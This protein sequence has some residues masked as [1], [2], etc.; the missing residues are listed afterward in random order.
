MTDEELVLRTRAGDRA[1]FDVLAERYW[2]RCV[3]IAWIYVQHHQDAEDQAQIALW[4]AYIH[5]DSCDPARFR[6]W[7]DK[8]VENQ[9][10]MFRRNR[11]RRP[12]PMIYLHHRTGI[13]SQEPGPEQQAAREELVRLVRR[14]VAGL[15]VLYRETV[16]LLRLEELGIDQVAQAVAIHVRAAK[17]R[18]VRGQHELRERLVRAGVRQ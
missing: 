8:I 2:R 10:R 13:I 6:S 15:P 7:L 9:C 1:A 16:R 18:L 5:L 4:Q 12:W 3:R 17:S 14:E 11:Q